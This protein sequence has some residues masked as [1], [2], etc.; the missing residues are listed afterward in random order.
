[1]LTY[2]RLVTFIHNVYMSY[3]IF[4]TGANSE[5]YYF[6]N[7]EYQ[8]SSLDLTVVLIKKGEK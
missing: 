7:N 5:V 4:W 2:L 1:M 6:L 8:I 3:N